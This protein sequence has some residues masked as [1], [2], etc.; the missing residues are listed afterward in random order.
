MFRVMTTRLGCK[1][2]LN[3]YLFSDDCTLLRVIISISIYIYIYIYIDNT[4]LL[5][6]IIFKQC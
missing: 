5:I 4:L 1:A 6:Y 3:T 2:K